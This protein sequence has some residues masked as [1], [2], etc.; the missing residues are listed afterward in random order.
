MKYIFIT[1]TNYE[2][3]ERIF[4]QDVKYK[5]IKNIC[6]IPIYSITN[7]RLNIARLNSMNITKFSGFIEFQKN[8]I[9][10]NE[11]N[12]LNLKTFEL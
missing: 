1:S 7:L 5:D 9:L 2:N 4:L 11:L 8:E 12:K 10:V 3:F 6:F